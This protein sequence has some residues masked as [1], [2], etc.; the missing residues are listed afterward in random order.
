LNNPVKKILT[1]T[2]RVSK[3]R[4][5]QVPPSKTLL[6]IVYF[7]LGMTACLTLL[8]AVHMIVLGRWNSEIFAAI[9]GLSG[10]VTGIIVGQRTD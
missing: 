9:T 3:T 5:I 6:Y 7:S 10:T 1:K 2:M 8:E 4:Y